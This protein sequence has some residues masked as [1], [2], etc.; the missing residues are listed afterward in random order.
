ME[1]A[2][3][4]TSGIYNEPLGL[5]RRDQ[6]FDNPPCTNTTAYIWKSCIQFLGS[7]SEDEVGSRLRVP[8]LSGWGDCRAR[9]LQFWD[10]VFVLGFR[11]LVLRRGVEVGGPMR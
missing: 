7:F 9:L 11:I 10:S 3:M 8:V 2:S 1:I 6:N 5:S 4:V